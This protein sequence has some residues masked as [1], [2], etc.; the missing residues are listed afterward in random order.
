[1]VNWFNT[2]TQGIIIAVIVAT[3]IEMILPERK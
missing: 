1:M 2:W 3:L